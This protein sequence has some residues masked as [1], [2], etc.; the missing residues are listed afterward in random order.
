MGQADVSRASERNHFCGGLQMNQEVV[1][2]AGIVVRHLLC[3]VPVAART[4]RF[5]WSAE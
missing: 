4:L 1:G 5:S 3:E 2:D